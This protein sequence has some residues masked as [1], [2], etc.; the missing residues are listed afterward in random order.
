M[1]AALV[2]KGTLLIAAV[3]GALFASQFVISDYHHLSSAR[4]MV[5]ATYAAGYNLLFGYAGLLSLGHAMFFAAG[6]FGSRA[7]EPRPVAAPPPAFLTGVLAGLALSL[8]GRPGRA[9]HH[10]CFLHDRLHD[11]RPGIF[12][13]YASSSTT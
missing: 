5:L 7:G 4:I 6:L 2:D 1:K 10:R 12:P 11:A 13:G 8:A 9:A 3:I